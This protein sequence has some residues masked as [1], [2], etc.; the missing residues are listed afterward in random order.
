MGFLSYLD[1]MAKMASLPCSFLDLAS[2][3]AGILAALS[4]AFAIFFAVPRELKKWREQKLAERKA[5]VAATAL[6]SA[7]EILDAMEIATSPVALKGDV[8]LA[9]DHPYATRMREVYLERLDRLVGPK[10]DALNRV[11]P[12]VRVFLNEEQNEVVGAVAARV[13]E[14]YGD[15]LAWTTHLTGGPA[16]TVHSS[17]AYTRLMGEGAKTRRNE[18][19][20]R[21]P[22]ALGTAARF[23]G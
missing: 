21:V 4:A 17:E 16:S 15:V 9:E 13:N 5:E 12:L 14:A 19:R 1:A 8:E 23:G 2:K 22:T 11:R 6:V 20:A 3:A 10:L 18:L 7:M